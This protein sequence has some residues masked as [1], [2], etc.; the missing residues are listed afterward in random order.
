MNELIKTLKNFLVR[1]LIYII[2]GSTVIICLS[3]SFGILCKSSLPTPY[4]LFIVG[5]AYAIG[6]TIQEIFSLVSG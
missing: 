5:I 1:D 4:Y 6:Y 3:Y 2:G